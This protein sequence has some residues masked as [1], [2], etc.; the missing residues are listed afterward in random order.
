MHFGCIHLLFPTPLRS[1]FPALST[2]LCNY[3][4][5]LSSSPCTYLKLINHSLCCPSTLGCVVNLLRATTLK[6]MTP[7][8][9]AATNCHSLF[10]KGWDL[11]STSPFHTGTLSML[12]QLLW[13]PAPMTWEQPTILWLDLNPLPQVGTH[14]RHHYLGPRIY[15]DIG[16]GPK[17]ETYY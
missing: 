9:P 7:S 17:K 11:V 5:P 2:Q 4:S 15:S 14:S 10:R 12:P 3:L 8:L 16:H 13:V 1:T 6:A